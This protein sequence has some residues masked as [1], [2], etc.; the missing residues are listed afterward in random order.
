MA[1]LSSEEEAVFNRLEQELSQAQPGFDLAD[2]YY[3]G[4]QRLEQLGLAIPPEL[5][6]FTVVVN[7]NLI[8]VDALHERISI[9]GFKLP[10]AESGDDEL[11]RVFRANNLPAQS[12]LGFLDALVYGRSYYCVGEN[13]DDPRTPR[14]T[15]ESP[16]EVIT[17]R[18]HRTGKVR[19]ALRL[20]DVVNGRATAATLY[21]RDETI[22]LTSDGGG[23]EITDSDEHGLGM[24]P[25]VPVFHRRRLTIPTHRTTQGVSEM[26]PLIPIVDA[27]ARNITN[28]QLAQETHAVPQRG[29]I[30]ASK[31]DFMDAEGQPL[32]V[33]EAYFG[34]VWAIT[35]PQA[36]HFQFDSSSMDNFERMMNLY[37]RMASGVS[38]LPASYFGLAADD[39]ASADAI[40]SREARLVKRAELCGENFGDPTAD[41]TKLVMRIRDGVWDPEV[42]LVETLW[43]DPATP[44]R[45]QQAD[46][47]V[48]LYQAADDRG[49]PL[50]PAE[51][52]YEELG[53][54]PEKIK[55]A[56]A[57]RERDASDPQLERITRTFQDVTAA[58][59]RGE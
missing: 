48:K 23:W 56:L 34:A 29:V 55:R 21:L 32:P 50:L 36:K 17:E 31:G 4:L 18:D 30:G 13:E 51:M 20:Y 57:M 1:Q 3:D 59:G 38:G 47:I 44:T 11:W 19:A 2:R 14:V 28:A 6:R 49:R 8:A 26:A 27:A 22:W 37:A 41:M 40:R 33:W 25:V 35:N 24:V 12:R 42:N 43:N 46:A 9:K 54:G 53:W 10:G 16:R 52:A 7:W 58:A 39:A 5:Q 15:V 45:A